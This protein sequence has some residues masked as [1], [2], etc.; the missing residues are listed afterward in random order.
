[1]IAG[2][3]PI[4]FYI[5][6]IAAATGITIFIRLRDPLADSAGPAPVFTLE[7]PTFI[8]IMA[9]IGEADFENVYRDPRDSHFNWLPI[10]LWIESYMATIF[11]V[12][13]MVAKMTSTYET[14]RAQ[15]LSFR[16]QQ[17]CE[18]II[19]FK[20]ERGLPPPLNLVEGAFRV[21]MS[22]LPIKLIARLKGGDALTK[23]LEQL[24]TPRSRGFTMPM[25]HNASTRLLGKERRAATNFDKQDLSESEKQ[26]EARIASIQEEVISLR[27]SSKGLSAMTANMLD[28]IQD[29]RQE[30]DARQ[31]PRSRSPEAAA[32]SS[33]A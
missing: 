8:G 14:I 31:K 2:S 18:F 7:H 26:V 28:E 19:E 11:L 17:R 12:N 21:L 33:L 23:L 20:D 16:A 24:D 10:L 27:S 9:V 32:A 13:M 30:L 6:F 15:S 4:T 29:L 3:V 25:G 5:I 22:M 1:M